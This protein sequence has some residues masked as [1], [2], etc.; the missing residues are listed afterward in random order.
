MTPRKTSTNSGGT[1]PTIGALVL[2]LT[3]PS[4]PPTSPLAVA[5]CFLVMEAFSN[6]LPHPR[7]DGGKAVAAV[8]A[9]MKGGSREVFH[10]P[11]TA[12]QP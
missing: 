3:D 5:A 6:L 12:R 7:L 1:P 11:G 10:P 2:L 8:W 4:G 9:C